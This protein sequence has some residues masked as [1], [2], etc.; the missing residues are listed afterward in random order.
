MSST[1]R[2]WPQRRQKPTAVTTPNRPRPNWRRL[3]GII[4]LLGPI[5][6]SLL[7]P[8]LAQ[9]DPNELYVG[10]ALQAPSWQFPFGA[11]PL[12]RDQL[13]RTL[14]GGQTALR[15]AM[16]VLVVIV[17]L[18]IVVGS[19]AGYYGGRIDKGLSLLLNIVLALPSLSFTLALMAVLGPG[20]KSL[21]IALTATAWAEYARL[22]RGAVMAARSQLF[23]EVARSYGASDKRIL[24]RHIIPN[25]ARPILA[26]ASLNLA[27]I[28]LSLAALSFLGLGVQP[29]TADWGTML[30]DARPYLR[31]TP[32]LAVPPAACIV[33]VSLGATLLA[34]ALLADRSRHKA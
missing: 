11:D 31:T 21:L 1:L 10:E 3:G 17:S 16:T 34:D 2:I 6:L 33:A 20:E 14:Y 15:I 25:V 18:G 7:A 9:H 23:V 13:A 12:G 5:L 32:Y 4:L 22:F 8:Q 28:I 29:P 24:F 19:L 27:G 30:S 26:L